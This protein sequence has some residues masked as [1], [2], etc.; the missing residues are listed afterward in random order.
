MN[1]PAARGRRHLG[2]MDFGLTCGS[3]RDLPWLCS[4]C[5]DVHISSS[6]CDPLIPAL[7][8]VI[9]SNQSAHKVYPTRFPVIDVRVVRDCQRMN[10]R[11]DCRVTDS[12]AI[13]F[14]TPH[15]SIALM[16]YQWDSSMVHS[17]LF[18]AL[19]AVLCASVSFNRQKITFV[20]WR[21]P[22]RRQPTARTVKSE[23]ML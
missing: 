2:M 13:W 20:I 10:G 11:R 16:L 1:A 14:S 23:R 7:P 6:V 22:F 9:V 17:T 15:M 18:V 3:G 5:A 8:A 19:H 21:S 12:E 4:G